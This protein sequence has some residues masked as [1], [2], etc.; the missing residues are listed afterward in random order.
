M[1]PPLAPGQR[2]LNDS[3]P[4]AAPSLLAAADTAAAALGTEIAG[5]VGAARATLVSADLD[6]IRTS[7]RAAAVRSALVTAVVPERGAGLRTEITV[8]LGD[9]ESVTAR[10]R[11]ALSTAD[12]AD[13]AAAG[14]ASGLLCPGSSGWNT[15]LEARLRED[16]SFARLIETY[17]GTIGASIGGRP[18]HIRCYR[19]QVLEVVTRS[20]RG[21]DFV[22][23]IPGEV[24]ID[25]M[26][27]G[28]NTFM[29]SAMLGKMRSTGSGYEYLRMTTALVRII[30]HARAIAGTS[31]WVGANTTSFEPL[32]VA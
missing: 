6:V 3:P 15:E 32:Q 26:S 27:T 12:A 22:L 25:L 4:P 2:L 1:T 23:D 10:L 21:A 18:V 29:E 19:G 20:V 28:D 9:E 5:L 11:L 17:D 7:D 14:A 31:G 13:E 30:D 24:F 16:E 8:E